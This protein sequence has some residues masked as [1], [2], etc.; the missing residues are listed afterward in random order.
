MKET[1]NWVMM[2][3][4]AFV[5][6][7]AVGDENT[8]CEPL[9]AKPIQMF[10]PPAPEI[11]FKLVN[12]PNYAPLFKDDLSNAVFEEDGWAFEGD[13]LTAKG[14]G[15]IWTKERY[16]NF[17]LS[18][19]FKCEADTNSGIFFRCGDLE[20]WL[21]TSI[22]AQI[23]QN[24]EDYDNPRHHCGGI[25]DCLAP[26]KQ[27]VKAPDEWNKYVIIAREH[28]I[29]LFLNNDLTAYMNL[30]LWTEPHKNPD[31]TPNKFNNAYKDMPREGHIG[32]QYHGAPIWF[33]NIRLERLTLY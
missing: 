22:E 28:E 33:R 23:L 32:L 8:A 14:K 24:N 18:L 15:D 4:L 19:E 12:E 7:V 21:H 3:S 20:N 29:W 30:N 27:L 17:I 10:V 26:M 1:M 31:G 6:C 16:G 13:V 11:M 5:A 25:F 9:E 2:L